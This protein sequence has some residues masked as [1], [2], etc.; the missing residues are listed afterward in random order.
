M[1]LNDPAVSAGGVTTVSWGGVTDWAWHRRVPESASPSRN[2]FHVRGTCATLSGVHRRVPVNVN[3]AHPNVNYV[4]RN[5]S[6]VVRSVSS[7]SRERELRSSERELRSRN[8]N[9]TPGYVIY[10][11][12]T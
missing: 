3:Y 9:Y 6:H 7:R 1:T 11:V 5:V 10:V 2:P 4:H 8:V 12:R